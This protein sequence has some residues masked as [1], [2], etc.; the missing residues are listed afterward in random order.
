MYPAGCAKIIGVFESPTPIE[1]KAKI[2]LEDRS[3][4]Q[5]LLTGLIDLKRQITVAIDS[6]MASASNELLGNTLTAVLF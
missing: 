3:N 1:V 6:T 2:A 4:R 5:P